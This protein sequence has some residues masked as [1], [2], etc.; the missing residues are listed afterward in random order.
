MEFSLLNS[1]LSLMAKRATMEKTTANGRQII[2]ERED[3]LVNITNV[4]STTNLS[5]ISPF[6]NTVYLGPIFLFT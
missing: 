3:W 5:A 6:S 2:S 4:T 1:V